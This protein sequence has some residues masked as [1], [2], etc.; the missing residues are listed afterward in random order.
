MIEMTLKTAALLVVMSTPTF[1]ASQTW[2]VTE[3]GNTGIKAGQGTWT[4]TIDNNKISGTANMQ[5]NN[6][7]T[8][9]YNVDGSKD[10][11]IYTIAMSKRPDGKNDCVWTGHRPGAGGETSHGYIGKV[12]CGGGGGFTIRVGF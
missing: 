10:G 1:A 3:E 11:D 5:L 9:T 4:L 6:G 12:V 2:N 7:N 8:L